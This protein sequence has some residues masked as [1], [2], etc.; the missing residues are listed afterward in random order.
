MS[1][2]S[3]SGGPDSCNVHLVDDADDGCV[4]RGGLVVDRF[5]GGT[6]A[7]D[8]HLLANSRTDRIDGH[9]RLA[10]GHH[11]VRLQRLNNL[12]FAA[13][14][15]FVLAGGNYG[16]NNSSY[17]HI[18]LPPISAVRLTW[19]FSASSRASGVTTVESRSRIG[20]P[21][22]CARSTSAA[23]TMFTFWLKFTTL[24]APFLLPVL[25][26]AT[27]FCSAVSSVANNWLTSTTWQP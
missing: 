9:V 14:Q 15:P 1:A 20:V 25:L 19:C 3:V 23:V 7:C 6:A 18:H 2:S 27:E 16:S 11:L 5:A 21:D 22:C 10:F 17:L 8:Q 12:D 4:H 13:D 26:A 24:A